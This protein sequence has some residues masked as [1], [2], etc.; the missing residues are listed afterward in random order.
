MEKRLI[1]IPLA[2]PCVSP[3]WAL[4]P[5]RY[6]RL[7]HGVHRAPKHDS[8]HLRNS[9]TAATIAAQSE[10]YEAFLTGRHPRTPLCSLLLPPF[11]LLSFVS[12]IL[13]YP[14]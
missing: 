14:S 8:G 9:K 10:G 13:F 3:T 12:V 2:S 6:A 11:L 4:A 5:V 7:E 1:E